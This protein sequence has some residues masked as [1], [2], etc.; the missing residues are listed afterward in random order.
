MKVCS[1]CKKEKLTSEFGKRK[2]SKD[3]LRGWC[4][5]CTNSWTKSWK[6]NPKNRKKSQAHSRKHHINTRYGLTVEEYDTLFT[7]ASCWICGGIDRLVL[8]H[9]HITGKVRGVL[10]H[11]CN[12]GLGLFLDS[13]DLLRRGAEWLER[14]L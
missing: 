3:G 2:D 12:T 10:C 8:D 11:H 1:K 9:C 4:K 13:P 7:D 6:S 14:H 5:E